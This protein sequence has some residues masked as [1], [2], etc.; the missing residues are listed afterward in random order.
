MDIR[1]I[2]LPDAVEAIKF[3]MEQADLS[4]KPG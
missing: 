1:P 4:P 2:D 3:R